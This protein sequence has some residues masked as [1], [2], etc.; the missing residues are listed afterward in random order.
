MIIGRPPESRTDNCIPLPNAE[1]AT[2]R[3]WFATL[4]TVLTT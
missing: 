4:N 1:I 3:I 2:I